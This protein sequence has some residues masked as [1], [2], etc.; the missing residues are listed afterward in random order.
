MWPEYPPVPPDLVARLAWSIL[1][2]GERSFRQDARRLTQHLPMKIVSKENIPNHGPGVILVN[3]Y[4]RPG[5]FTA[6][7]ALAL[8]AVVPVELVWTMTAAWTGSSTTWERIKSAFSASLFP[9]LA[10]VYGFITMPPM[11]PR[12]QEFQA[13]TQA[14]RQLLAAASRQPPALLAIA[15]EGQDSPGAGLMRPHP[16]V[17]RMLVQLE[18]LGCRFHPVGVYEN[19]QALVLDFGPAFS[20]ALPQGLPSGEIDRQAADAVMLAVAARLPE[21]LRGVYA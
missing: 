15:P 19:N 10:K 17:G 18:N 9:R 2:D 12:P 21:Y 7:I 14:V 11:P 6:W 8:S 20:I 1:S 4:Y 13:R 3:H 16:G 5:F